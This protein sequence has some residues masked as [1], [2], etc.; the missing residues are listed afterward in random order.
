V[1]WRQTRF[2]TV[3]GTEIDGGLK[4]QGAAARVA[5]IWTF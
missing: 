2:N 5:T 3:Q 1:F 4:A